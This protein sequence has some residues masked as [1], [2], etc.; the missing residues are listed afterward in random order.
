MAIRA[1]SQRAQHTESDRLALR[2]AGGDRDALGRLYEL[3]CDQ[4][5]RFVYL[6]VQN[7]AIAEDVCSNLWLRVARSISSFQPTPNAHCTSW[8]YTIA[9]N[10]ITD[11]YREHAR[12]KETP[13]E[14][15]LALSVTPITDGPEGAAVDAAE[16]VHA[17][18]GLSAK[19]Q[20]LVTLRYF[21]GL[22]VEECADVLGLTYNA[23]KSLH[24]RALRQ[25]RQVLTAHTTPATTPLISPVTLP[26]QSVQPAPLE[27]KE[28]AA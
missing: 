2:A 14:D 5:Y 18:E 20:K 9:R 27:T 12:K 15:M 6:R 4:L 28:G 1:S 26:A 24:Y 3:H 25:M 23:T 13:V 19:A 21:V 8:L 22:S 16:V 11:H 7:H 10:L 17:L